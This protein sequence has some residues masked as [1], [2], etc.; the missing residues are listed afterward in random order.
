MTPSVNFNF[1]GSILIFIG[2]IA[3]SYYTHISWW[4]LGGL[5]YLAYARS[6]DEDN[7]SEWFDYLFLFSSITFFVV[8][9][10]KMGSVF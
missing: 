2:S 10:L 5:S 4:S 9:T 3:F 6:H 7:I 8:A 1:S